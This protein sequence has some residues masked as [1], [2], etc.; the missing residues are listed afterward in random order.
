MKFACLFIV[1]AAMASLV[2]AVPLT[3]APNPNGYVETNADGSKTPPTHLLGRGDDG[4]DAT[5]EVAVDGYTVKD[6]N[7]VYMEFDPTS[8]SM[9]SSGLLAGTDNPETDKSKTTGKTLDKHEHENKQLLDYHQVYLQVI[10]TLL[11]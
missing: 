3:M 8:G 5:V 10:F 2:T 1:V 9:V 4:Y 6:G 11:G 7:Y